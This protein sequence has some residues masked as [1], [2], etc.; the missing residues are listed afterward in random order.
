MQVAPRVASPQQ[1]MGKDPG[2]R[3][4]QASGRARGSGRV[5]R[6][7][8]RHEEA[9]KDGRACSQRLEP[10][11]SFRAPQDPGASGLGEP[12]WPEREVRGPAFGVWLS[13]FSRGPR[14]H[15][16]TPAP[17]RPPP[18]SQTVRARGPQRRSSWGLLR[19]GG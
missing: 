13:S 19:E 1:L 17:D 6:S 2:V 10:G 3:L 9:P 16:K 7:G 15:R 14:F 12:E 5:S 8:H 18:A 4:E 11:L